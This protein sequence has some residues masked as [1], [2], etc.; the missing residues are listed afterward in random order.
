MYVRTI[1]QWFFPSTASVGT[2]NPRSQN[3]NMRKVLTSSQIVSPGSCTPHEYLR[4]SVS[5]ARLAKGI[6]HTLYA[7]PVQEGRKLIRSHFEDALKSLRKW[8]DEIPLH[9]HIT[10]SVPPLHRRAV[11][12]LHLRYWSA[13]ILVT[14]PFLLCRLLCGN[15][16]ADTL[17]RQYF[18][19]LARTCVSAADASINIFED[20][21]R[22]SVV[23]SLVVGDFLVALQ[24]LQVTLVASALYCPETHRGQARRCVGILR[25]IGSFGCPKHLLQETLYEL[26]RLDLLDD[27]HDGLSAEES[28]HDLQGTSNGFGGGTR[29]CALFTGYYTANILKILTASQDPRS[30]RFRVGSVFAE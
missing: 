10:S 12:L 8:L 23:S 24:V 16:L 15:K 14:R 20:M 13:V 29:Y 21:V 26:Q 19:G 11:A 22:Q 6:R 18:D 27:V 5:L 28:L 1:E 30:E 9:L 3:I 25:A 17:K 2:G 7:G 4:Y